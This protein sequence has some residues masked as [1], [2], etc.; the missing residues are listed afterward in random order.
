M[1]TSREQRPGTAEG[2]EA[3]S[4]AP[5]GPREDEGR[6]E[7]PDPLTFAELEAV[8]RASLFG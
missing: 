5:S 6:F 7:R 2:R 4:P 1:L 3:P 8:K